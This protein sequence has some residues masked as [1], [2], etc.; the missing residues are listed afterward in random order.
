[1]KIV[2]E[3]NDVKGLPLPNMTRLVVSDEMPSPNL[4][5]CSFVLAFQGDRLLLAHLNDRG[6]DIP[7]GH[8]ER[9]E[10]PEEAARRELYEETGARVGPLDILGYEEIRLFGDKPDGYK[11]PFPVS[12]MVFYCAAITS[13]EAY[14]SNRESAG[15][16]LFDP[17][18]AGKISWV[19]DSRAMYEEALTRVTAQ[20]Q[21]KNFNL[22]C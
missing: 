15:R 2:R 11:Y 10:S 17:E 22:E 21:T 14:G 3:H 20:L 9:G 13:M 19:Q 6:W 1:M 18:Q 5:T 16:A 12:C 4:V 7:G 8:I